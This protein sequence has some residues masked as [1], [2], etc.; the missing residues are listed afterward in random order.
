MA[1]VQFTQSALD[2]MAVEVSRLR[3]S[4]QPGQESSS[5]AILLKDLETSCGDTRQFCKKIRRRMP[6][7]DVPGIPAAVAFG[8]QVCCDCLSTGVPGGGAACVICTCVCC[9]ESVLFISSSSGKV[10]SRE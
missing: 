10:R 1:L 8:E 5:F 3:A 7:A 9:S 4:L 6:N 2:C